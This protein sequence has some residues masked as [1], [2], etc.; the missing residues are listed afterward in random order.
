MLPV[1]FEVGGEFDHGL[2]Q[3]AG[4]AGGVRGHWGFLRRNI[5]DQKKGKD[6]GDI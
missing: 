5:L 1:L 3:F 2:A 6:R 4:L